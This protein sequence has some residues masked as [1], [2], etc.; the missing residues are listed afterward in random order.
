[1][2]A[3]AR[4]FNISAATA[5]D[6]VQTAWLRLLERADSLKDPNAV[7]AWLCAVVRN[8]ARR[9]VT[10]GREVPTVLGLEGKPAEGAVEDGLLA[11]ERDA[12]MRRAFVK[13]GEECQRLLRLLLAEPK[14]SYDE[15]AAAVG[16]P[17]GALGPT[18]RRC[19]DSLRKHLPEGFER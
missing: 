7:G 17:R 6:L 8:E 1:M 11:D 19:L 15:V 13:L 10:R 14:L 18:R 2:Y 3:V 16:R 9:A 12:L 5:E 4:S